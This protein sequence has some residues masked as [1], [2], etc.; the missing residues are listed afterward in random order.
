MEEQAR[1][2]D[3]SS[4]TVRT[5]T[6]PEGAFFVSPDGVLYRVVMAERAGFRKA[7]PWPSLGVRRANDDRQPVALV[8]GSLLARNYS[9]V[10][11]GHPLPVLG[12]TDFLHDGQPGHYFFPN[13]SLACWAAR[14]DEALARRSGLAARKERRYWVLSDGQHDFRFYHFQA[15]HPSDDIALPARFREEHVDSQPCDQGPRYW[16]HLP[17]WKEVVQAPAS[18][19]EPLVAPEPPIEAKADAVMQ[20][21]TIFALVEKTEAKLEPTAESAEVKVVTPAPI[22]SAPVEKSVVE[23]ELLEAAKTEAVTPPLITTAPVEAAAV[24]PELPAEAV[25]GRGDVTSA[26]MMTAPVE[27]TDA[28]PTAEPSNGSVPAETAKAPARRLSWQTLTG[29]LPWRQAQKR[30]GGRQPGCSCCA[31]EADTSTCF[32]IAA[33]LRFC[34]AGSRKSRDAAQH[35]TNVGGGR[36]IVGREAGG[37]NGR[38]NVVGRNALSRRRHARDAA[39]H[40]I[41]LGG[42]H[43]IGSRETRSAT[44]HRNATGGSHSSR[45]HGAESSA[46]CRL[47]GSA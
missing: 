3:I 35:G 26:P 5:E 34:A 14:L 23:P 9:L 2:V 27:K 4:E 10:T 29:C 22:M 18:A 38:G 31:Q 45:G 41:N 11:E 16:W 30:C 43:S 42:G 15:D 36:S 19:G 47:V 8:P 13:E 21:P 28:Q 17:G 44:R 20:A 46:R 12:R 37:A 33:C 24:E 32:A 6:L 25:K 39:R 40:R 1:L 7:E